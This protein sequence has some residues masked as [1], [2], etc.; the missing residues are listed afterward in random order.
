MASLPTQRPER[1]SPNRREISDNSSQQSR[2]PSNEFPSTT[3]IDSETVLLE[4]P[5]PEFNPSSVAQENKIDSTQHALSISTND[6]EP[7]RC[8]IC[9]SDETEDQSPRTWRTPCPCALT[10]H[11]S[12]LL[13]WIADI[14]S[15]ATSQ[16]TAR[17]T[18]I[19]CPQCKSEIFL[20]RPRDRLVEFAS[21]LEM[22]YS[23]TLLPLT[24]SSIGYTVLLAFSHHGAHTIRTV[25]GDRDAALI[26]RPISQNPA[27]WNWIEQEAVA[28]FP[29]IFRPLLREWR[30]IRVELGLPFIPLALILSRTRYGDFA[31]PFLTVAFFATHP[32][33]SQ[34]ITPGYWPPSAALSLVMLPYFRGLYNELMERA[35]GE[36]ERGW[37]MEVKPQLGSEGG[38]GEGDNNGEHNHDNVQEDI[39]IE[40]DLNIGGGADS[41]TDSGDESDL[42]EQAVHVPPAL[43]TN[44]NAGDREEDPAAVAEDVAQAFGVA[45]DGNAAPAAAAAEGQQQQ[46]H[47]DQQPN[48]PPQQRQAQHRHDGL[49]FSFF[50]TAWDL[51]DTIGGA[52][53]FPS[54]AAVTGEVL[55]LFLP[56]SW[57]R[58]PINWRSGP[59]GFL[60]TKWGRSIL[61]GCLFVVLKDAMRIY[62]RWRMAVSFRERKIRDYD[63][64]RG[65]YV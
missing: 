3:S 40:V 52:L 5:N 1:S 19:K 48:Q 22:A 62:C 6:E 65:V 2:R 8:W 18:Q 56:K 7:R 50:A 31:L 27:N 34:T 57:V 54:I 24:L 33:A 35:W 37:L 49:D 14:E 41:D 21:N 46:P 17:P 43:E 63:K 45:Q 10:A 53:M 38:A 36:R 12:C 59:T 47:Q 64:K 44:A 30:G 29:D 16:T 26:L 15:P 39:L 20:A 51:T 11:E 60:Q 23:K 9:F 58:R 61:G 25:F 32:V 28:R 13:D 55:K 4:G 42:E